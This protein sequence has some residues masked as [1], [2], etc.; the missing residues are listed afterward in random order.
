MQIGPVVLT[1]E[2]RQYVIDLAGASLSHVSGGFAW[3]TGQFDND[4]PI[5][6]YLDEI[7]YER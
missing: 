4:G 6:F 5:T 1:R 7:R 3:A 2:W